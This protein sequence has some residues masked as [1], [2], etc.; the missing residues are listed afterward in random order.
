MSDP[1]EIVVQPTPNPNAL[2]F[3]LNRTVASQGRTFRAPA[4][5]DAPWAQGLLQL[6]GVTQVFALQNFVSVSKS[7][8]ADWTALSP[9]IQ[10]VLAQAF[11]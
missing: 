2:K 3:T 7:T 1:L 11:A 8:E 4:P 10:Q 6:P 5:A 9:Q